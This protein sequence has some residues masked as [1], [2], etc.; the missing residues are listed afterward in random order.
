M[1]TRFVTVRP[2]TMIKELMNNYFNVYRKSEFPVTT[3]EDDYL[4]GSVTTKQAMGVREQEVDKVIVEQIMTPTKELIIMGPDRQ[5][6][7]A[8]KRIY[9]ENKS[10]VFVC[11]SSKVKLIEEPKVPEQKGRGSTD[12]GGDNK[13]QQDSSRKERQQLLKLIGIISKSDILNIAKERHEY[14]REVKELSTVTN[15]TPNSKK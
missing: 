13:Q 4:L 3:S 5:A 7:E 9:Q 15:N 1:N 12:N 14:E 11:T 10:R 6:D 2:D 8:L